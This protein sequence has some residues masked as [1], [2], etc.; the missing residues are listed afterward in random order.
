MK[1]KK[2]WTMRA[3]MILLALVLITSCFVSGTF[4]KYVTAGKGSDSARVAKFGVEVTAN[5][6][7]FA[8][9]Y[10]T[11]DTD[12]DTVAAIAKSVISSDDRKVVAPGTKGNMISMALSG[13][14]EVAVR[15]T[16]NATGK[17][18]LTNWTQEDG[19]FY[20]PLNFK[21]GKVTIE[22]AT[23]N[24]AALLQQAIET[25]IM[26]Y[27]KEYAPKTD[28]SAAGN[29]SLAISWEWPFETGANAGE[30]A[31]NNIKDTYLG[32]RAADGNAAE[33]SIEVSTTVTQI[34]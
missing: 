6:T 29:D 28:L 8:K 33:V 2:N 26:L 32:K 5:G 31:A 1:V 19:T 12:P 24:S 27:S 11:D 22:G 15:V 34:D 16:Y 30:K 10:A 20:C 17:V 9:E 14:P 23:Y 25:E 13:S 7:M 3:A 21:I 18:Q 4:A